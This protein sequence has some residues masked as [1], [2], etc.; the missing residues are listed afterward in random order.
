MG[1]R[2]GQLHTRKTKAQT[3]AALR[4]V[5]IPTPWV[6]AGMPMGSQARPGW[7]DT[8]LGA[9]LTGSGL[10]GNLVTASLDAA[11]ARLVPTRW[12]EEPRTEHH[13]VA[14]ASGGWHP[15]S[16]GKSSLRRATLLPKVKGQ[17]RAG[18][19]ALVGP[20]SLSLES[21]P[22]RCVQVVRIRLL[23]GP[24]S[25]DCGLPAWGTGLR[26]PHSLHMLCGSQISSSFLEK[27]A[28]LVEP[29][30]GN[31]GQS[32]P[33]LTPPPLLKCHQPQLPQ[34]KPRLAG[35]RGCTGRPL[36]LLG[37]LPEGWLAVP[38][39]LTPLRVLQIC[40]QE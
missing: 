1:G 17:R 14:C 6:G 28:L 32:F 22:Q 30:L 12:G 24:I 36:V 27:L 5:F 8:S 40:F 11:V 18:K 29:L 2:Q 3:T 4:P 23:T 10:V 33:F 38:V 25:L 20:Q 34:S 39:P 21:S 9:A 7:T 37:G 31:Q 19:T 13:E 16:E 15:A 35:T 26:S